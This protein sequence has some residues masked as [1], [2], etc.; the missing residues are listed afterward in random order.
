MLPVAAWIGFGVNAEFPL[1]PTILIVA[2]EV[3]G[4]LVPGAIVD[5]PQLHI[6]TAPDSASVDPSSRLECMIFLSPLNVRA[7]VDWLEDPCHL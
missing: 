6:A 7:P 2:V 5:P 4:W 3:G 1:E